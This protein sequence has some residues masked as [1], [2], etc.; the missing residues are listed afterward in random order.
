MGSIRRK[1]HD[2]RVKMT[3]VEMNNVTLKKSGKEET[4]FLNK[5][6]APPTRSAMPAA[7]GN[8]SNSSSSTVVK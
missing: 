8:I 3:E 1:L 7:I 5:A 4:M 6:A 2:D